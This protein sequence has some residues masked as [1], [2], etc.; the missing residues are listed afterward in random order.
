[1]HLTKF[2]QLGYFPIGQSGSG[3]L[4]KS[5]DVD[6][7]NKLIEEESFFLSFIE[8]PWKKKIEGY[9]DWDKI[10]I[11]WLTDFAVE[12]LLAAFYSPIQSTKNKKQNKKTL[13]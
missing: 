11:G 3:I 2:Y 4:Q 5:S 10:P 9:G 12:F 1:M 6:W 7:K 13:F 8:K